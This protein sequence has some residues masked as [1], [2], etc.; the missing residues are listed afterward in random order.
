MT[1]STVF[2]PMQTLG[3]SPAQ[4]E[5]FSLDGQTDRF[6]KMVSGKTRGFKGLFQLVKMFLKSCGLACEN[7]YVEIPIRQ[8]SRGTGAC[9][10]TWPFCQHGSKNTLSLVGS[11]FTSENCKK[12]MFL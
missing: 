2:R 1:E 11:Y 8:T 9:A 4:G 5:Q 7:A 10:Y 6:L 3:Q 12:K